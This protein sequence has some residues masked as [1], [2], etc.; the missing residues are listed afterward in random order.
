MIE[1]RASPPL[2]RVARGDYASRLKGFDRV[3]GKDVSSRT[4]TD[5]EEASPLSGGM[6]D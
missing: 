1:A 2:A 3:M 5:M 6:G 4:R